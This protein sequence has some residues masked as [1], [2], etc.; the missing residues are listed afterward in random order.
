MAIDFSCI[1]GDWGAHRAVHVSMSTIG[2]RSCYS[3]A[4]FHLY[5]P[6]TWSSVNA[7]YV[8]TRGAAQPSPQSCESRNAA[9]AA[10]CESVRR[11]SPTSVPLAL[12]HPLI[13][14]K[15][16]V[17]PALNPAHPRHY[18]TPTSRAASR[19]S[20]VCSTSSSM[21]HSREPNFRDPTPLIMPRSLARKNDGMFSA[22]HPAHALL[23]AVA[24]IAD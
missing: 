17:T 14:L 3:W 1:S 16:G 22:V 15:L 24:S 4:M 23:V 10:D 9:G 2:D 12:Y 13:L 7:P 19:R 6:S 21:P 11:R 20:S 18:S 8:I 5:S